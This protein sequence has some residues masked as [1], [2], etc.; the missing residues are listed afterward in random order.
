[1]FEVT[2]RQRYSQVSL[3]QQAEAI[4]QS[5]SPHFCV[6]VSLLSKCQRN[7]GYP[8][9]SAWVFWGPLICSSMDVE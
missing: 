5:N 2:H 3:A 8:P 7:E 9:P 6:P 1:M 4:R